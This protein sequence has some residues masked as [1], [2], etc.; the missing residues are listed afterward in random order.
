MKEDKKEWPQRVS[1]LR[2]CVYVCVCEMCCHLRSIFHIVRDSP[3]GCD[4]L[5]LHTHAHTA[6][7]YHC[8]ITLHWFNQGKPFPGLDRLGFIY[9]LLFNSIHHS[10][11]MMTPL[12]L[13][14][15]SALML[16]SGSFERLFFNFFSKHPS[17]TWLQAENLGLT[18]FVMV[19][20]KRRKLVEH[21]NLHTD[22]SHS[23]RWANYTEQ[24]L[25][26]FVRRKFKL[27]W[28]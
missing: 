14:N 19:L 10:S 16:F 25:S 6:L 27:S 9:I 12:H 5:S 22:S 26:T 7:L 1:C 11:I 13:V 15:L 24:Y 2:L 17:T 23:F 28:V 20:P 3:N 21:C 18:D 4:A 8:L